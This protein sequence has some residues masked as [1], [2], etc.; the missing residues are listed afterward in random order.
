MGQEVERLFYRT[1]LMEEILRSQEAQQIIT[2]LTPKYGEAYTFLWLIQIIGMQ[3]DDMKTWA[4]GM[5][6]Q[7]T[8]QTATWSIGFWE[9]EYGIVPDPAWTLEQRRKEVQNKMM[10]RGPMNPKRLSQIASNS[11]GVEVAVKERTGKN[12]FTLLLR[13][14]PRD[15]SR[16]K[17]EVDAAK[18]AH[19]IY[20]FFV[21]KLVDAS[22][23]CFIGIK[24]TQHKKYH[25]EVK[26]E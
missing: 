13:D 25:L 2:Y 9:N 21:Q 11:A 10:A 18:P 12:K 24:L 19:L 6:L 3:L 4:E 20:D 23:Q 15:I 7:V 14:Y 5:T 17:R 8:P 1:E 16:M 22:V 26:A